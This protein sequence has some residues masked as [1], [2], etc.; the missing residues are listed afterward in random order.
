MAPEKYRKIIFFSPDSMNIHVH[1]WINR[2]KIK[3]R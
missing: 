1:T 2:N 3:T